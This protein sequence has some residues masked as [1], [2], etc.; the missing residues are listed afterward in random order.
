MAQFQIGDAIKFRSATRWSNRVATRII[1]GTYCGNPT[2]RYSGC[3]N[4]IV[5]DYEILEINGVSA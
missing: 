5:R 2:V 3:P 1:N 4:F